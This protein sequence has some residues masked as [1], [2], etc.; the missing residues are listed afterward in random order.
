MKT[1]RALR[2]LRG[3]NDLLVAALAA[4]RGHEG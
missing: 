2:G 1:L 4:L 3:E